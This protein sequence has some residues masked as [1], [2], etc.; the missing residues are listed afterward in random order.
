MTNTLPPIASPARTR[1]IMEEFGFRT[2]KQFGQNFLTNTDVLKRIVAAGGVGPDDDVIEIGPGIGALTEFLAVSAHQVL[3]LEIDGNLLPVLAQTMAP[4]H[5]V[6]VVNQDVLQADLPAMIAEHFDG[7]HQ[8]K[9]VANLPYYITT[10]IL[11]H[12][13]NAPIDIAGITVMMQKEVASRLTARPSTKD[14]GS[15]SIAVQLNM[16]V[17]LAFTVNRNSFVPAPNVDSAIV[18]LSK[19]AE[20]LAEV[21]DHEAF[22]KLVKGSF[23][24]RRKTLWNN[25]QRL[26]GKAPDAKALITQALEAA[27]IAPSVRAETLTIQQF[28]DLQ[29]NLAAVGLK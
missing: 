9:V 27:N 1:A 10:P 22:T 8:V 12:L 14:Y 4:Y 24:A 25:L 15:L 29:K 28:A 13:L 3:A 11:M 16:N 20:P 2:K 23:A 21:E 5:N 6:E 17:E 7:Q 18:V 19:R 26:Y